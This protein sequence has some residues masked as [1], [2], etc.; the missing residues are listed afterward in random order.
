MSN[1]VLEYK[2]FSSVDDQESTPVDTRSVSGVPQYL[3]RLC[4]S[5]ATVNHLKLVTLLCDTI[6]HRLRYVNEITRPN[7][8]TQH[9]ATQLM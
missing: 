7:I 3:P 2:G 4:E 5:C 8:R 9:C 1:N 6:L